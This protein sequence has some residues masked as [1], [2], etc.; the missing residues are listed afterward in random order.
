MLCVDSADRDAVGELLPT[1]VFEGVTTNPQIL[2]RAGLGVDDIPQ[3]C[4][5]L[6]S[7]GVRKLFVQTWGSGLEEMRHAAARLLDTDADLVIKVP[8]TRAGFQLCGELSRR[9]V[10]VLVTM[11]YH[12]VQTLVAAEAGAWGVAPY[13]G[14]M[15]DIGVSWQ[16]R[17]GQMRDILAHTKVRILAASLRDREMV[18]ECAAMGIKDFTFGVPLARAVLMDA[19]TEGAL[20]EFE[21]IPGH[22]GR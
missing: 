7:A 8:A 9:G 3:L 17:I 2:A 10:P 20:E 12:P 19:A 22:V 15:K 5:D 18:A 4:A 1:G 6:R 14:R 13:V 11:V 16:E 21:T